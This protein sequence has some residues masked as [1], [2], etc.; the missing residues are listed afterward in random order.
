MTAG[1]NELPGVVKR[2]EKRGFMRYGEVVAVGNGAFV[3]FM[4]DE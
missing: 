1:A 2:A 3:Q 4:V